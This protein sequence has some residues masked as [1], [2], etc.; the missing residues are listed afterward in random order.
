MSDLPIAVA[1][2]LAL[3]PIFLLFYGLAGLAIRF[4]WR[5]VP[6]RYG[7]VRVPENTHKDRIKSA[8]LM[9]FCGSYVWLTA[10][11]LWL[12]LPAVT[13]FR[14]ETIALFDGRADEVDPEPWPGQWRSLDE[15]EDRYD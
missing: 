11:V 9:W 5:L 2:P 12:F 10:G 14:R 13:Q 1:G 8:L 15:A 3:I 4:Q 6:T 7:L